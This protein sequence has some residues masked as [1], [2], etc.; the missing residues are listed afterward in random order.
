[1]IRSECKV[2]VN[3]HDTLLEIDVDAY[4]VIPEVRLL[5]NIH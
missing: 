2:Q 3:Y 5:M 1:M 4:Q